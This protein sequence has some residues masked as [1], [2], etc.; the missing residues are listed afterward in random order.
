MKKCEC[1]GKK[2]FYLRPIPIDER[3]AQLVPICKRCGGIITNM[4]EEG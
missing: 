2:E 4:V 1:K 3:F